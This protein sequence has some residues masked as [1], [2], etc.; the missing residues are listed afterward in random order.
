MHRMTVSPSLT[1]MTWPLIPLHH[2]LQWKR[3]F[4]CVYTHTHTHTHTQTRTHTHT[5]ARTHS[6]RQTHTH[7]HTQTDTH[8]QT[9]THT[10]THIHTHTHTDTH[11]QTQTR[12][13]TRTHARTHAHT[14][15]QDPSKQI[16]VDELCYDKIPPSHSILICVKV[17]LR[18]V[19]KDCRAV[20]N[21]L[22]PSGSTHRFMLFTNNSYV[23]LRLQNTSGHETW[24]TCNTKTADMLNIVFHAHIRQ[25]AVWVFKKKGNDISRKGSRGVIFYIDKASGNVS[26]LALGLFLNH[27][28]WIFSSHKWCLAPMFFE[29][30]F[31]N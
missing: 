30:W 1:R 22:L 18:A 2:T 13:H 9:P 14:H 10:H 19:D 8:T 28:N 27:F 5:H 3:P 23:L 24:A 12:T 4:V 21:P 26:S 16:M 11:T 7:T 31:L 29:Y 15:T 20:I 25:I 6:H 17:C